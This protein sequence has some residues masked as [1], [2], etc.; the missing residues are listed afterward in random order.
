MAFVPL[1][2]KEPYTNGAAKSDA[3]DVSEINISTD[4]GNVF[5]GLLNT[6]VD[7]ARGLSR[8]A[9]HP[10]RRFDGTVA[11]HGAEA[12]AALATA[13][14]AFVRAAVAFARLNTGDAIAAG[15]PYLYSQ[16]TRIVWVSC[17]ISVGCGLNPAVSSVGLSSSV[18]QR[19]GWSGKTDV[20]CRYLGRDA[21]H[22]RSLPCRSALS[23]K[24]RGEK[25]A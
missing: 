7:E 22:S 2:Q 25:R 3:R 13:R 16:G 17:K 6:T 11:A 23:R 19:H 1:G 18:A 5:I 12:S 8:F 14:R 10:A 21:E 15:G 20:T 4:A 9:A 24:A